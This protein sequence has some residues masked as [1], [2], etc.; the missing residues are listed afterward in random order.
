MAKDA[1]I[2]FR[3]AN[4]ELGLGRDCYAIWP[5]GAPRSQ[6][7]EWWPETPEGWS[8]A[9][10]RFTAIEVPGTVVPAGRRARQVPGVVS[11]SGRPAVAAALLATGV[12][13]GVAGLFPAYLGGASLVSQPASLVP[14]VIYL[15]AWS[16][17]AVLVLL[18]ASRAR[19]G[20][21]IAAGVSVVTFGLFFADAGTVI[22]GGSHLMGAGLVLGLAG[23]LVCAAGSVLAAMLR[24]AGLQ[25]A[26]APRRPHARELGPVLLLVLAGL[27]AA[28]AFAPSWDSY[29]L[30]AATGATQSFTAGYAFSSPV[31]VAAGDVVAMV[32]L[33]A[34]VAVAALWHPARQGAFLL[35]GAVLPMAA[36]A[37]SALVQA[38]EPA[39][40]SQLGISPAQAAQAGLTISSGLTP[41]FWIFCLFVLVLLVSC[42]WLLITPLPD[43]ASPAQP[44]P[45]DPRDAATAQDPERPAAPVGEPKT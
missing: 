29:V 36:Q 1:I 38:G 42:T 7:L 4:Y 24:P 41:A 13:L 19:A 22:A 40:P 45:A 5:M 32:A 34:A 8:A 17:G 15:A 35:G 31:P 12:A 33:A 6:P 18:G 25:S 30:R 20:A 26:G 43:P 3:G 44:L 39:S 11:R 28:A 14:H 37:V 2:A 10:A 9:C 16:A 21:L 27:G 23:W